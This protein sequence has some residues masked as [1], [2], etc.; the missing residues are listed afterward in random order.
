MT[1]IVWICDV[2]LMHR[3]CHRARYNLLHRRNIYVHILSHDEIIESSA[4]ACI[5]IS[6][7]VLSS[8]IRKQRWHLFF[9]FCGRPGISNLWRVTRAWPRRCHLRNQSLRRFCQPSGI[10]CVHVHKRHNFI[11][12]GFI[13]LVTC[14]AMI[15]RCLLFYRMRA[16]LRHALSSFLYRHIQADRNLLIP[17]SD[18]IYCMILISLL[19]DRN[20][21]GDTWMF[22]PMSQDDCPMTWLK[23]YVVIM[24]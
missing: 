11:P 9:I 21:T 12:I 8:W 18:R 5:S 7:N 22:L 13:S 16:E 3:L 6:V 15:R 10:E 4:G 24:A 1:R 17:F 20:H 19:S 14:C 23:H 2:V